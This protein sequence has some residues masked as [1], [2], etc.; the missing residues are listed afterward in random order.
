V[1][2]VWQTDHK[3]KQLSDATEGHAKTN[4]L[5]TAFTTAEQV[6]NI[7]GTTITPNAEG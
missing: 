6:V 4:N 5:I 2:V 3:W 7:G 1:N